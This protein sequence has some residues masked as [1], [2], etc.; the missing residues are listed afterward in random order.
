M[1][2]FQGFS[3]TIKS[4]YEHRSHIT[5]KANAGSVLTHPGIFLSALWKASAARSLSERNERCIL[6]FSKISSEE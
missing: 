4:W 5:D 3:H 6:P 2:F 1:G